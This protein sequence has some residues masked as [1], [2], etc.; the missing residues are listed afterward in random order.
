MLLNKDKKLATLIVGSMGPK[1]EE[2]EEFVDKGE[3]PDLKKIGM[4]ACACELME[5]LEERDEEAVTEALMNFISLATKDH[6]KMEE[7]EKYSEEV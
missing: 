2:S 5:A 4:E 3:A 7:K 6:S 1:G